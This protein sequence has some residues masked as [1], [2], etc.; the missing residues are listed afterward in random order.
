MGGELQYKLKLEGWV[1]LSELNSPIADLV[2]FWTEDLNSW[3]WA[4]VI[5]KYRNYKSV[6]AKGRWVAFNRF[7]EKQLV[8]AKFV[9]GLKIEIVTSK[10]FGW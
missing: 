6:A 8:R 3:F 5:S 7:R 2:K 10:K 4:K 1:E 9:F